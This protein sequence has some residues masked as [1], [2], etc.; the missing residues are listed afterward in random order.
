MLYRSQIPEEKGM[1]NTSALYK[2]N[3]TML[4]RILHD[5]KEL[6]DKYWSLCPVHVLLV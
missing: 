4:R 2:T 6:L 5:K 1:K 3:A